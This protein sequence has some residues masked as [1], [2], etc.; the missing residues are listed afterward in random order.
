MAERSSI[1][2]NGRTTLALAAIIFGLGQGAIVW[3]LV[4]VVDLR[5]EMARAQGN[6]WTSKDQADYMREHQSAHDRLPPQWIRDDLE[7]IRSQLDRFEV[8]LDGR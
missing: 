8:R 6:R 1:I 4:N 7:R 5:A 3:C 2:I